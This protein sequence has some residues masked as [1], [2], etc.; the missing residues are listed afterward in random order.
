MRASSCHQSSIGVPAAGSRARIAASSAGKFFK[1]LHRQLVLPGVLRTGRELAQTHG[2][3]IAP[4]GVLVEAD[5]ERL[6]DP[7][8]QVLQPP[9]HHSVD[10]WDRTLIHTLR[11][12]LALRRVQLRPRPRRLAVEQARRTFGVEAQNPIADDLQCDPANL[13]RIP[14][15]A[16]VVNNRQRQKS[17]GLIGILGRLRKSPKAHS[18]VVLSKGY[19]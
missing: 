10:R 8:R 13:G 9:A 19:W 5:A 17:P 3:Q 18:V 16:S 6:E 12:S 15:L 1:G 14:A 7:L 11:Q 2:L 4:Q